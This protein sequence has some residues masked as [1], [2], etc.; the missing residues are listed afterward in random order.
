MRAQSKRDTPEEVEGEVDGAKHEQNGLRSRVLESVEEL[1]ADL[2]R[3]VRVVEALRLTRSAGLGRFASG[4][5]GHTLADA[6]LYLYTL[7]RLPRSVN[8]PQNESPCTSR[9]GRAGVIGEDRVEVGEIEREEEE[10]GGR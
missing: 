6:P 7:A 2:Q 1:C 5:S 8:T 10:E 4:K 3:R 9:I